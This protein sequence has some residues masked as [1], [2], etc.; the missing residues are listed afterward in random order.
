MLCPHD[1]DVFCQEIVR[2]LSLPL[3]LL[4]VVRCILFVPIPE[5]LQ[6]LFLSDKTDP[7]SPFSQNICNWLQL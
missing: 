3:L 1:F 4:V 6:M 5:Q 7:F 2:Y